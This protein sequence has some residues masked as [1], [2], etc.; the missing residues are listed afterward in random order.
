ME[1][2]WLIF[3]TIGKTYF[4]RTVLQNFFAKI[5]FATMSGAITDHTRG[6]AMFTF[7]IEREGTIYASLN[8]KKCFGEI[9]DQI[10]G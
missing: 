6:W 2:E 10:I 1:S 5:T 9:S 4:S 3:R 7:I 8:A